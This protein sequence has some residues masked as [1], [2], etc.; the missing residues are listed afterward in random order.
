MT[1][2]RKLIRECAAVDTVNTDQ[3]VEPVSD[4]I[5]RRQL[6]AAI[7]ET[8][9]MADRHDRL[10][11]STVRRLLLS[12]NLTA[13]RLRHKIIAR[14][15]KLSRDYGRMWLN[16]VECFTEGDQL[17]MV[18]A[19]IDDYLSRMFS[20]N[21]EVPSDLLLDFMCYLILYRT[22]INKEKERDKSMSAFIRNIYLA[23]SSVILAVFFWVFVIGSLV[24]G[25]TMICNSLIIGAVLACG[26]RAFIDWRQNKNKHNRETVA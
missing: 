4:F 8:D 2:W 15:L 9:T 5:Y 18:T 20:D 24:S 3:V 26:A 12:R 7:S 11:R 17:T 25:N 6:T 10:F 13:G 1:F 19:K 16:P 14:T 23:I 22:I 21:F